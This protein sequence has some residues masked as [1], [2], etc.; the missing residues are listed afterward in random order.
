M[1][2]VFSFTEQEL[3]DLNEA[4]RLEVQV[5]ILGDKIDAMLNP[6]CQRILTLT[7]D[8]LKVQLPKLVEKFPRGFQRSEL[9]TIMHQLGV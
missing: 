7:P 6:I 5:Q 2:D 4:A 9:R 1:S 8:Q 3:K